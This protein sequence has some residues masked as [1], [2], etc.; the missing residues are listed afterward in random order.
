[1]DKGKKKFFNNF[2]KS[3]SKESATDEEKEKGL[4]SSGDVNVISNSDNVRWVGSEKSNSSVIGLTDEEQTGTTVI[5]LSDTFLPGLSSFQFSPLT[6]HFTQ[7]GTSTEDDPIRTGIEKIVDTR[8]A[9]NMPVFERIVESMINKRF[10]KIEESGIHPV[11][12]P[13]TTFDLT[14]D[15]VKETILKATNLGD[16]FY[17]SDIAN[18]FGLDLKTVIEVIEDLKREGKISESPKQD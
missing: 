8:M 10:E 5:D 7:T 1:M 14:K 15:Q 11:L 4:K 6:A 17:P 18:Q 12:P 3:Y 13:V 16:I 2:F 9:E